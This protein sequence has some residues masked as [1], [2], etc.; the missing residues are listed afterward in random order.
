MLYLLTACSKEL[1]DVLGPTLPMSICR[2]KFVYVRTIWEGLATPYQHCFSLLHFCRATW[3][4]VDFT[5]DGPFDEI[6][7]E[8]HAVFCIQPEGVPEGRWFE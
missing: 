5:I 7:T 4:G 2:D 6:I 3:I 1:A 8:M